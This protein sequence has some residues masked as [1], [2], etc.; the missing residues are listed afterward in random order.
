MSRYIVRPNPKAPET[1]SLIVKCRDGE[2][3]F[4]RMIPK[5]EYALIRKDGKITRERRECKLTLL[6]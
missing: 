6:P 2:E 5:C 1:A 4:L 3:C